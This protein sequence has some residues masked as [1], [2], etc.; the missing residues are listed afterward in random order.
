MDDAAAE[1]MEIVT[2]ITLAALAEGVGDKQT[3][4]L[5]DTIKADEIAMLEKLEEHLPELTDMVLRSQVVDPEAVRR[6]S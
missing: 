3:A 1:E 4:K 6:A 5:A 2:Y